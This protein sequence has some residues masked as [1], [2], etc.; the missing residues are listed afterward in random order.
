MNLVFELIHTSR[1]TQSSA[2]RRWLRVASQ[3]AQSPTLQHQQR[4]RLVLR[5]LK[6]Q[7]HPKQACT[8]PNSI[9]NRKPPTC[10]SCC[11]QKGLLKN[12]LVTSA[13][14]YYPLEYIVQSLIQPHSPYTNEFRNS[15]LTF[16]SKLLGWT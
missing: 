7:H 10:S 13:N 9:N 8:H 15:T 4:A 12:I 3:A 5:Y 6:D 14:W 2:F 11:H 1:Q 16:G